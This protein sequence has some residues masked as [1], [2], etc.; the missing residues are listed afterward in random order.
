MTKVSVVVPTRNEAAHVAPFLAGIPPEVELVVADAGEDGTDAMFLQQRPARTRVLRSH[1]G[2]PT[3]RNLGA[4]AAT[5][6][7]LVFTD[8]DVRFEPGYF[9]RLAQ[10]VAGDAFYGPK[11]T[12]AP[13][14]R[15]SRAFRGAQR[16]LHAVGIPAASGSNMGIRRDVFQKLGGY[17]EDLVVN[18]D[19]EMMMRV[20]HRGFR[21][22][23]RP[24]LGVL[25]LDDRRLDDGLTFKSA[26]SLSRGL[27]LWLSFRVPIPQRWLQ[28]DWGYWRA[29]RPGSRIT[30]QPPPPP[31][32]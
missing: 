14:A 22:D 19:T 23:W 15:Y 10:G 6:D 16:V 32:A 21:V 11:H 12:T 1:G 9:D 7:W 2:I 18:E 28:H 27:L 20:K 30:R 25:S 4:A 13:Y 24:D 17:R 29:R 8:A 31:T 5:G 3:A 26:H